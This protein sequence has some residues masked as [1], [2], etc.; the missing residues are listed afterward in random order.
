GQTIR[1]VI[2]DIP[3]PPSGELTPFNAYVALSRIS[4]RDTIQLLRNFDGCL[5]TKP[6]CHMLEK[7]DARLIR[8]TEETKRRW[9]LGETV[10]DFPM[11]M[12]DQGTY[13]LEL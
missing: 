10:W 11:K 8:P 9:K 7:E 2:M 6:P 5:F 1:R 13:K 3:R 12:L 4:G